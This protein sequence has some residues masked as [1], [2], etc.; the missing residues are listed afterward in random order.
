MPLCALEPAGNAR[1]PEDV[2]PKEMIVRRAVGLLSIAGLILVSCGD[3]A[4]VDAPSDDYDTWFPNAKHLASPEAAT[5]R[6]SLPIVVPRGLGEPR[7][8]CLGPEARAVAFVYDRPEFGRVVIVEGPVDYSDP[9]QQREGYKNVVAQ[10]DQ[11]NVHGTAEMV[12]VTGD[13]IGLVTT[14]E[15]G[16]RSGLEIVLWGMEGDVQV[17][18]TG[19]AL[20]REQALLIANEHL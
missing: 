20:T 6:V 9:G 5:K 7:C 11:P 1:M 14:S 8:T 19:P 15:D 17:Y 2:N 12:T 18:I 4:L 10:N 3:R 13:V 16:S